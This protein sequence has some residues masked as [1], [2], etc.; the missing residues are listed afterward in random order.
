[1]A[2][3]VPFRF[4][5]AAGLALAP[6]ALHAQA[7]PA[8]APAAAPAVAPVT[9]RVQTAVQALAQDAAEY[10]RQ[11]GVPLD[12]AMR[13]LRAQEES[14]AQTDRIRAE[15][16]DRL[17]GISVEHRPTYRIQVLLKG[18]DPVPGRTIAAGGMNVP[19]V[20]RTG[21]RATHA[22]ILAAMEKHQTTIRTALPGSAGMGID[23]RTG[24]LVLM[25]KPGDARLIGADFIAEELR[26]LTGV[27]A[28]VRVL[29]NPSE[30]NSAVE[31]GARVAGVDPGNG[32]RYACTTGFVVTDGTQTAIT[33]AAHCPDTLTYYDPADGTQTPLRFVGQWGWGYRDVQVH[34]SDKAREPLFYADTAK[35]AARPVTS[36]RNRSSTR[37]GDAVC[38]RGET[39]GYSCAQ[40]ELT[41]YAPPGDLCGGPCTPTW[42]TVSG[43]TCKG[44]DSGGP[45]FN[46]TIA[47]GIIK[48]ASY[49]SGR[50][51][52]Y[53]YMST[54]FLPDGWSLLYRRQ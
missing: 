21:A 1:M 47:Y 41:D 52:F 31:G 25:V 39:T 12:E 18:D 44:G 19:V 36:W 17:A 26:R 54:D 15:F 28:R 27:P 34:L 35:T 30:A 43:P 50:C 22:E 38:R 16:R 48:G 42:V 11:N 9:P 2:F 4:V 32:V 24:E 20:F 49:S 23:Q 14:A 13:R 45:V 46:G 6:T 3:D 53:Y 51:N 10:A 8:S 29:E 7:A 5:F 37:A 33:T 40:V